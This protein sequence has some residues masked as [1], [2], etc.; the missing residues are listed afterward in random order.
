MKARILTG[1]LLFSFFS[2][3]LWS[4]GQTPLVADEPRSSSSAPVDKPVVQRL[5]EAESAEQSD[6]P[7]PLSAEARQVAAKLKDELAEGTEARKMLDAI[8]NGSRMG[9]GDG[10]FQSERR[11]TR[12]TW[13]VLKSR[14][15]K[16][17]DGI[18]SREEFP[19]LDADFQRLDRQ[20]PTGI[21]PEDLDWTPHALAASPG[22]LLFMK[23]DTDSSG[24]VTR[25]EFLAFYDQLD[26]EH[27]GFVSLDDLR[28]ELNPPSSSTGGRS[29]ATGPS[30]EVLL[31][32][33]LK[34]EIGAWNSGPAVDEA[35][36][37]FTLRLQDGTD[38]ITLSDE[39]KQKPVVLIFGN[40]TCGPFRAQAGN[41]DDLVR[42]YQDRARF[43][44]VYVREAHPQD[45]WRMDFNDRMKITIPQ[46][47]TDAER[48]QVAGSCQRLLKLSAPLLVDTI[49]D[50][51]GK[52]WSGMPSRMYVIDQS[53]HIVYQSGRGPFGFKPAE[54][55]QSLLWLLTE[56]STM[57]SSAGSSQ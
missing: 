32:G 15:D 23:L 16:D 26:R 30:R 20:P 56:T 11:I 1:L 53:G 42:R 57:P 35:A 24:K 7:P 8:L 55:E 33:L 41:V 6:E 4:T 22:L 43:L 47:Q 27:R 49:D 31:N 21:T 34:Q 54:M 17:Q 10:W 44:M 51:V 50:K 3:S 40:F 48:I 18:I 9:P 29:A 13:D 2:S 52:A 5:N 36:P 39:L 45:G 37:D 19:G 38:R 12:F 46:P 25:E 14:Y 28:H